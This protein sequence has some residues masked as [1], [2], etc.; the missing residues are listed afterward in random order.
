MAIILRSKSQL[1]AYDKRHAEHELAGVASAAA[2]KRGLWIEP[3]RFLTLID[4]YALAGWACLTARLLHAWLQPALPPPRPPGGRPQDY[5]DQSVLLSLLVMRAWRVSQEKIAEWLRRDEALARAV[6]FTCADK[7]ISAS[8]L[9]R[10]SRQLGLWPYLLFF[11]ALAA[12]LLRLGAVSGSQIILD[13]SLLKAWYKRDPEANLAGRRGGRATYGFKIHALV[14]R[15]SHLP[16]LFVI[17]PAS[18][19]EVPLAPFLL[20]AAVALYGLRLRVV[21]ADAAYFT[22][23]LL[24]LIRRLG[25]VPLIDY[26][27]RGLGKRFLA[28]LFFTDQWQRLRAPRTAVERTFAFLKRYYGLKYFQVKGLAAVWRYALLVH[29]AMLAVA[30]IA[31]RCGRP[32]L[33]TCRTQVLAYATY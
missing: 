31:Y 18:H 1:L 20:L 29:S 14:D 3:T 24:G 25:A 15:Y 7:T 26:Q 21:Y 16:L 33:M 28:T 17:T 13:A 10:R 6:G 4:A 8:Q 23:P 22:Y 2:P 9:S 5:S 30:L 27:L 19:S 12:T 11:L 32:D